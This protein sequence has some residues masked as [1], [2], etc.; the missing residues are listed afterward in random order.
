[1]AQS[2]KTTALLQS[3]LSGVEISDD[4]M[5]EGRQNGKDGK[6]G[7]CGQI[8]P[9]HFTLKNFNQLLEF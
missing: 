4:Q 3:L 7:E 8:S 6:L 9:G 2:L 5:D 1:V